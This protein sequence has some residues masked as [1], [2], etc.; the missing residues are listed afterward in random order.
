MTGIERKELEEA[1]AKLERR[2]YER[3]HFSDGSP[4][5]EAGYAGPSSFGVLYEEEL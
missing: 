5:T 2:R 3:D 4:V 1:Q